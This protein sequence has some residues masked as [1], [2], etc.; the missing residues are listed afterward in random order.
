MRIDDLIGKPFT[1]GGRGPDTYDCAG[2]VVEILRRR[3]IHLRIPD[4]PESNDDQLA[5]MREIMRANWIDIPRATPGCLVYF[6]HGHVG[7]MLSPFSFIHVAEDVGQV[8]IE[9]LDGPIWPRKFAGFYE[10]G[11]ARL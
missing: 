1:R 8:C 3:N 11:G 9:R 7:I 6:K 2:L 10:Y 4:T 5:S